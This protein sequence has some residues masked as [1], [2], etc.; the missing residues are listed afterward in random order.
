MVPAGEAID[1]EPDATEGAHDSEAA[2]VLAPAVR[3]A[4]FDRGSTLTL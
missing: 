1:R 3:M 4:L 2:A